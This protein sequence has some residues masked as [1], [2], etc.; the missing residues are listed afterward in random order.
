MTTARAGDRPRPVA[1]PRP[2]AAA[3]RRLRRPVG[4]RLARLGRRFGRLGRRRRPGVADPGPAHQHPLGHLGRLHL[5]LDRA[6]GQLGLVVVVVGVGVGRPSG[7]GAV[8]P[9]C[10]CGPGRR[11]CRRRGGA[12]PPPTGDRRRRSPS[13]AVGRSSGARRAVG[14]AD[15]SGSGA[16]SVAPLSRTSDISAFPSHAHAPQRVRKRRRVDRDRFPARAVALDPLV[17]AQHPVR[18]HA[19]EARVEQL[20]GPQP[21]GLGGHVGRRRP[22]RTRSAPGWRAGRRR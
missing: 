3:R 13:A 11:G 7:S 12:W 18:L 14:A 8:A 4:G 2:G 17:G 15:A 20:P 19:G 22:P 6:V 9:G 5:A 10:G 16:A 21:P 1:P